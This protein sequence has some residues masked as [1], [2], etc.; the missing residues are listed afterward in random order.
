M[1][2]MFATNEF[3]VFSVAIPKTFF[4]S[5]VPV[6]L[7]FYAVRILW[8]VIIMAAMMVSFISKQWE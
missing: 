8:T 2:K 5:F 6:F 7:L 3:R 4:P 1:Q